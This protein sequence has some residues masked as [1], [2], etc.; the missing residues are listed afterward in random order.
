MKLY[1]YVVARDYGFAPNPFFRTCTLATCKPRIRSTAKKGD[2]IVGTSPTKKGQKKKLIYVMRVTGAKSFNE[3]WE[4]KQ[5]SQKKPN[6]RGSKMQAFGDNI[7][8]QDTNT[9]GWHQLDSHHSLE[10]GT[11][12]RANIENDT[13]VDR[14]L[15]GDDFVYWGGDGPPV[16]Q[17]FLNFGDQH[18]TLIAKR[19][20][21]S[22]FSPEF[23]DA[24][25]KYFKSINEHGCVGEP[26]DWFRSP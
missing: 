5:F 14:I 24:F 10:D 17:Q 12:N 9:K 7:Y 2:L 22:E 6:L 19:N 1:S 25:D 13:Q 15:L 11:P 18:E 23:I 20:H 21:R 8:H 3:Y 4:S 26:S 16:P